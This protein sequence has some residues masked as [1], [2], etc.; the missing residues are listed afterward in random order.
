MMTLTAKVSCCVFRVLGFNSNLFNFEP[1]SPSKLNPNGRARPK[2]DGINNSGLKCYWACVFFSFLFLGKPWIGAFILI[3]I[4]FFY[5]WMIKLYLVTCF[6]CDN[7]T[8]RLGGAILS[9][10]NDIHVHN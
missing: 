10:I 1:P 7:M 2:L 9:C 5:S 8:Y 6:S 4:L 3:H